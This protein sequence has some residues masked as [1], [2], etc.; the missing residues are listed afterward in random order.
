MKIED[1]LRGV[2]SVLLDTAPVIYHL[3]KN[4]VFAPV[5]EQFLRVRAERGIVKR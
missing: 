4:P 1:A 2:A 5:M 3:E